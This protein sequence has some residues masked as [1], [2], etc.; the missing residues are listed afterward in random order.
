[1]IITCRARGIFAH[2]LQW[3][4]DGLGCFRRTTGD[5]HCYD[6]GSYELAYHIDRALVRLKAFNKTATLN[7]VL[8]EHLE[9]VTKGP[10]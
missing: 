9:T 8:V 1:M 4:W 3:F 10:A 2:T 7:R 6:K 5:W